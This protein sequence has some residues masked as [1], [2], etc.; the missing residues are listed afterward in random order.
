MKSAALSFKSTG[1]RELLSSNNLLP[2]FH[3]I[4]KLAATP[5]YRQG[6]IWL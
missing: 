5:A 6:V 3:G 2:V 1:L 4:V